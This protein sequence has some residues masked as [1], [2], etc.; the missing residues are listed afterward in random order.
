MISRPTVPVPALVYT[1][2]LWFS[3][4]AGQ[5][6]GPADGTI[7]GERPYEFPRYEDAYGYTRLDGSQDS[8]TK[9]WSRSEY[10]NAIA[11]P[12]F[13]FQKLIYSSDGLR[14]LAYVLAPQQ[15][16]EPLPTL[17]FN[18]GSGM[19][20]DLAPVL[21]PYM[22]RMAA[23]GYTVIA[24]M[25]RQTDG[26]EGIDANGGDDLHDLLN[27]LPVIEALPFAD[28]DDLYMTGESRGAMM[29]YQAIRDRFPLRA[30]AVWGGFTDMQPLLDA[31]PLLADY[32]KATWPGFSDETLATEVV[33]RSAINWASEL[34]VPLLLMH[35]ERDESIPVSHTYNLAQA[36]QASGKLYGL[37]VFADDNHI[38]ARSQM[39]RDRATHR[40]FQRH[41]KAAEAAADR[42]LQT[43]ATEREIIDRG[44]SQLRRGRVDAAIDTFRTG[45][46]RYPDSWNAHDSLG[47]ALAAAARFPAAIDA[48][49]VAL[50]LTD[51]AE[52]QVRI[53]ATITRLQTAQAQ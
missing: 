47:E 7:L 48:Y 8:I 37:I 25:Y 36:L 29:V 20:K 3:F 33:R 50:G 42:H 44:Y 32:A 18:R 51:S 39:E 9:Y 12:R 40:W 11:D 52:E 26:G 19:H 34:D 1:L 41:S 2:T 28:A 38:L 15:F 46:R 10:E 4:A 16:S 22:Q 24:P 23:Y 17:I 14:V 45:V 30:A 35:G 6:T 5:E 49:S 27:L 43:A 31:E 53:R 13:E 21:L